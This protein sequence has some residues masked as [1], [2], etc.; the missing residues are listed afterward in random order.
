MSNNT[1]S[2]LAA[3]AE[4]TTAFNKL[5]GSEFMDL[6]SLSKNGDKAACNAI[7][8]DN[9]GLIY[10]IAGQVKQPKARFEDL[11][12][13]GCIRFLEIINDYDPTKAALSTYIWNP[14]SQ[15]M[16]KNVD[17]F[18]AGL[19]QFIVS[20]NETKAVLFDNFGRQPTQQEIADYMGISCTVLKNRLSDMN[21]RNPVSLDTPVSS[22]ESESI[23]LKDTC[24]CASSD[25]A[26]SD[27]IREDEKRCI[28][29]A[30]NRLSQEDRN[31]LMLRNS[32]SGKR[33]SL[34]EAAKKTDGCTETLRKRENIAKKH[35]Q[36][37]LDE[38]GIAA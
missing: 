14:L 31:T 3:N 26:S 8:L 11:V 9:L 16:N 13:D 4:S 15:Y 32:D 28:V 18:K 20:Y 23:T 12:S 5:S 21:D 34:R 7:L 33:I 24:M 25:D 27:V 22:D 29:L 6:L 2:F 38:Y 10:K 1:F 19:G 37:I 17:D 35:F 36:T 30:W